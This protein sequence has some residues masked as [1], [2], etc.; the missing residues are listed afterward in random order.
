MFTAT[1]DLIHLNNRTSSLQNIVHDLFIDLEGMISCLLQKGNIRHLFDIC[2]LFW[3]RV[4][5][6]K[7]A[8]CH[9]V[10][11][12][13]RS[14]AWWDST[15]WSVWL[16]TV[17]QGADTR[18]Q[19]LFIDSIWLKGKWVSKNWNMIQTRGRSRLIG[20]RRARRLWISHTHTHFSLSL[21]RG[22]PN[23]WPLFGKVAL[24]YQLPPP[25]F[26]PA[27]ALLK[28]GCGYIPLFVLGATKLRHTRLRRMD[29]NSSIFC[30]SLQ[31]DIQNTLVSG[32]S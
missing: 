16:E 19:E 1:F 29:I 28:I 3:S 25:L 31:V 27:K 11:T 24:S 7:L 12:Q 21:S 26:P 20:A 2:F 9:K 23:F 30:F 17:R 10:A 5:I 4:L 22:P 13:L 6:H 32:I 14:H 18:V 15:I 8:L